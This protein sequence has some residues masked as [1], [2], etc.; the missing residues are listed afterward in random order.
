MYIAKLHFDSL[1][2]GKV[3]K[4]NSYLFLHQITMQGLLFFA[5][6]TIGYQ[7]KDAIAKDRKINSKNHHGLLAP[8]QPPEGVLDTIPRRLGLGPRHPN[9]PGWLGFGPRHPNRPRGLGP[10]H[11]NPQRDPIRDRPRD[12]RV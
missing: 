7:I 2:R 4:F 9:L 11:P 12:T 8:L 5:F 6:C 1:S 3:S 10:G